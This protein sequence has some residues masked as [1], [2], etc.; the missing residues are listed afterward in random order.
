MALQ[1]V[2]RPDGPLTQDVIRELLGQLGEKP[3][4]GCRPQNAR[5]AVLAAV[6]AHPG[7]SSR[8]LAAVVGTSSS[9]VRRIR[10]S[11]GGAR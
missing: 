9:T 2:R 5:A 3:P 10:S 7:W 11:M 6:R 1:S 8:D 4:P